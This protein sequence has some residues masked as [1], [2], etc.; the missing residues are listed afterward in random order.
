MSERKDGLERL[1]GSV[2]GIVYQNEENGYTVLDFGTEQNELVTLVG[3]L[4]YI[5]E[6]DEMASPEN[7]EE[8]VAIK[9]STSY[10]VGLVVT[11]I[12]RTVKDFLWNTKEFG[13]RYAFRSMLQDMKKDRKPNGFL[14]SI[15]EYGIRYTIRLLFIKLGQREK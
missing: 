6:G 8:L 14:K 10:K 3:T 4:P 15:K 9:N 5:A 2:E 12:P 1:S 11:F 13:I 7:I